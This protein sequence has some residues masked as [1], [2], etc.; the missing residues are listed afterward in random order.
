ASGDRRV[1]ASLVTRAT[2][3]AWRNRSIRPERRTAPHGELH[4]MTAVSPDRTSQSAR[5]GSSDPE[6]TILMPCPNEAETIGTCVRKALEFL[7]EHG[8]R[9]EVLVADNRS[10]DGSARVARRLGARTIE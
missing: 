2:A 1:H 8:V 9:G 10:D 7:A 5:A 4:Q 6:L 3:L